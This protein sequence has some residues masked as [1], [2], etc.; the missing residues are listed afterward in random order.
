MSPRQQCI[1]TVA[2]THAHTFNGP[3]SRTTRVSRYQKGKTNLDFTEAIDSEWQWHQL[4]CMQVCT[5]L[6]TD[7]HASNPPLNFLHARCPS[8]HPTNSVKAL[9]GL[10]SSLLDGIFIGP[11]LL[12][13]CM[14]GHCQ[15]DEADNTSM[16]SS[17]VS[18]ANSF[19]IFTNSRCLVVAATS[20]E[21]KSKWIRDLRLVVS[22]AASSADDSSV[23]N[24][25]VLYPSLKSNS[26]LLHYLYLST[27]L[28]YLS[29]GSCE[30]H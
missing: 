3:L 2:Y 13:L 12:V 10:N 20:P 21:E 5:S 4:S 18:S 14:S 7:N 28:L 23:K 26:A 6:Q 11:L 27:A 25:R 9:K 19:T 16:I 30:C 1:V 17:P 22:A 24:P 29:C 15:I 8:C